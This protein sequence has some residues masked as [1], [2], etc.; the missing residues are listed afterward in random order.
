MVPARLIKQAGAVKEC[1]LHFLL[2]AKSSRLFEC[3]ICSFEPSGVWVNAMI[4]SQKDRIVVT[5]VQAPLLVC[6]VI[7][8]FTS[9]LYY[10]Y[11]YVAPTYA[12][13]YVVIALTCL[14]YCTPFTDN[15]SYTHCLATVPPHS[16]FSNTPLPPTF[17]RQ[18]LP[19]PPFS[20]TPPLPTF[21]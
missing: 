5:Y 3:V 18:C 19:H 10:S 6:I 9:P 11:V 14:M 4:Q 13:C 21:Q 17:Q 15:T 1:F 16:S 8:A 2:P 12:L 20:N 7:T